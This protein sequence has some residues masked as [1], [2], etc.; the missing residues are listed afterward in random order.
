MYRECPSRYDT[1]TPSSFEQRRI[2]QRGACFSSP[3]RNQLARVYPLLR[4]E[5]WKIFWERAFV[6]FSIFSIACSYCFFSRVIRIIFEFLAIFSS[7][8]KKVWI[9]E[10]RF[11]EYYCNFVWLDWEKLGSDEN[12]LVHIDNNSGKWWQT[13]LASIQPKRRNFYCI[14]VCL[15]QRLTRTKISASRKRNFA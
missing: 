6:S 9:F 13:D 15:T 11:D 12:S 7:I 4:V 5:N 14:T 8:L 2:N 1:R 3:P 10:D